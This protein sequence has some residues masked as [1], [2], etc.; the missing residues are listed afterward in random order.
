LRLLFAILL[1]CLLAGCAAE[2]QFCRTVVIPS[3]EVTICGP[4]YFR[5]EAGSWLGRNWI[6]SWGWMSDGQIKSDNEMLGHEAAHQMNRV[7]P[8]FRDPDRR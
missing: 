6:K 4:E 3:Q 2:P 8:A 1:L 7:D 5:G